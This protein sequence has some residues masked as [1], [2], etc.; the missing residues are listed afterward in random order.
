MIHQ[1]YDCIINQI[2]KGS[3]N[4]DNDPTQR[5]KQNSKMSVQDDQGVAAVTDGLRKFNVSANNLQK[6][7]KKQCYPSDLVSVILTCI[8]RLW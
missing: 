3:I 1:R 5:R 4:L 6:V 8:V 7:K 2:H